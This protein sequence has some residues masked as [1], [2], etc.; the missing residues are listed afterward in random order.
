[1]AVGYLENQF[2]PQ[3]LQALSRELQ[4]LG[5][6][7]LLFTPD[8]DGT[9]DLGIEK[10]LQFQVDGLVL[11]STTMSSSLAREC[12]N[13][14]I[15]V[16]MF[17]RATNDSSVSSV[18]GD[19]VNGARAIAEFLAASGHRR[20]CFMAG[21]EHTSTSRERE[22]GFTSWLA[23]NGYGE[24]LRIVGNYEFEAARDAVRLMCKQG[25]IPDALFCA[26]DHMALA[27]LEVCRSEFGLRIP[28]DISIVG[29]DDAGPARWPSFSLTSYSQPIE[30]MTSETTR[31][32]MD[33]I[34]RGTSSPR[35]VIVKGDLIV[36]NSARRPEVGVERV[37][38]QYVWRPAVVRPAG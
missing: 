37:E 22:H 36:R 29:F 31:L 6:Q 24:P 18:T 33:L 1:M 2:N 11:C 9:V 27:A 13:S 19:N 28:D 5:Y 16:V 4:A 14:G 15:P 34:Q 3:A 30:I 38:T 17:N 23:Q 8:Q 10:V 26:N 21:L 25:P 7:V 12:D 20:F 35:Q 32:L